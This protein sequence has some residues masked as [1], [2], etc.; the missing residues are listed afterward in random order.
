MAND[1][2]FVEGA[3]V[4]YVSRW[5]SKGGVEDLQ[6]ASHLLALLIEHEEGKHDER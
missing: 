6:K 5:Q 2:G 4:K 1:L 3:V